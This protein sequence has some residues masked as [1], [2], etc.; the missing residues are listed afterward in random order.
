MRN[1]K[2]TYGLCA[3]LV[4]LLAVAGPAMAGKNILIGFWGDPGAPYQHLREYEWT[5]AALSQVADYP[6]T[7]SWAIPGLA[8]AG[9]M[10][11]DA[12]DEYFAA[13]HTGSPGSTLRGFGETSNAAEKVFGVSPFWNDWSAVNAMDYTDYDGDTNKELI[14]SFFDGANNYVW[15]L[16]VDWAANTLTHEGA[17]FAITSS[18]P[19]MGIAGVGDPDGD[20]TW[21]YIAGI[22]TGAPGSI[23]RGYNASSNAYEKDFTFTN[24]TWHPHFAV[25]DMAY[26]DYDNDSVDELLIS[27]YDGAN[28]YLW[29]CTVDWANSQLTLEAGIPWTGSW[30]INGLSVTP[31]PTSLALFA[32]GA[33]VL[34]RRR[35]R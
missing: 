33:I 2:M 35:K 5:G 26:G 28:S 15:P 23:I 13:L 27:L 25:N 7:T 11:G 30:R 9:N 12:N 16:A 3:A 32:A 10:D 34:Y 20:S 19:I 22:H 31:E 17:N 4:V 21:E 29:A 24:V 18:W 8:H 14:V 6:V 1:T